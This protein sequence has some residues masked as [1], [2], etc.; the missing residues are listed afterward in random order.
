MKLYYNTIILLKNKILNL[1][2]L[3]IDYSVNRSKVFGN[4][5]GDTKL[6]NMLISF[7]LSYDNQTFTDYSTTY[8]EGYDSETIAMNEGVY[9][10]FK[11]T[12]LD[13]RDTAPHIYIDENVP[14]YDYTIE[15]KSITYDNEEL[16]F[17]NDLIFETDG[18]PIIQKPFWNLYDNH[19]HSIK[20]WIAQ[21]NAIAEM[22]GHSCI[23]FKTNPTETIHTLKQNYE[24]EVV[25]IKRFKILIPNNEIGNVDKI[26]YSE[27]D[28]PLQDDFIIHIVAEKFKIAFG[29]NEIPSEKDHLF[30]PLLN[31]MFRISAV[32]PV[33]SY[34]G[35]IGWW[36]ANLIKY[37]KDSTITINNELEQSLSNDIK[38]SIPGFDDIYETSEL[39]SINGNDELTPQ[40]IDND[41]IKSTNQHIDNGINNS[42]KIGIKTVQ[43]KRNTTDYYMNRLYDSHQL[44][45]DKNYISAKE[46]ELYR[47]FFNNRLSIIDI[48]VDDSL[49][50]ITLYDCRKIQLSTIALTYNLDTF[51]FVS[52]CL[53]SP[54]YQYQM[55]IDIVVTDLTKYTDNVPVKICSMDNIVSFYIKRK[56]TNITVYMVNNMITDYD[57]TVL[58]YTELKEKEL[59]R[60][61]YL[62]NKEGDLN[63]TFAEILRVYTVTDRIEYCISETIS[64]HSQENVTDTFIIDSTINTS[65]YDLTNLCLYGGEF[66][67]GN[68]TLRLD[69]NEIFKDTCNPLMQYDNM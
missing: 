30:L 67:L 68:F 63:A 9:V 25:A 18:T 3:N 53:R 13:V 45:E 10:R 28:M 22:Y 32:Q 42:E 33:N 60:F 51:T 65:Q 20:R 59:Y 41:Y 17:H 35:K 47:E 4:P 61:E 19:F 52:K 11:F 7:S 58:Q 66:L 43:E 57:I 49:F 5:A 29:D 54:K 50:P 26:V 6:D 38:E 8:I 37:E 21:C 16:N 40:Y 2:L 48:S 12:N 69:K 62:Y 24:R 27:W 46:S 44:K 31:K 55:V 56:D 34:M 14:K 64:Y 15:L 23:Y 39:L 1:D 36:E